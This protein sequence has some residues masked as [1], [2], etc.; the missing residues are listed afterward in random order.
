MDEISFKW[1]ADKGHNGGSRSK[2]A[3]QSH[4]A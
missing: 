2:E 1:E 4:S 3:D